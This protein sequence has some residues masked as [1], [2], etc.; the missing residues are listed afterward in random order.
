MA[1]RLFH[2]LAT[3]LRRTTVAWRHSHPL[4]HQIPRRLQL[5]PGVRPRRRSAIKA[6]LAKTVPEGERNS[7]R[8]V[9]APRDSSGAPN[10]PTSQVEAV[11]GTNGDSVTTP[12]TMVAITGTH[13]YSTAPIRATCKDRKLFARMCIKEFHHCDA[14]IQF[15]L[16]S[17]DW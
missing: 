12:Q 16:K 2:H 8:T 13:H 10:A 3:M 5:C 6:V 1:W 15:S 14:S 9:D 7:S 17:I 4:V 11:Q